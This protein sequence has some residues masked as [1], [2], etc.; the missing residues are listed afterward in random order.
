MSKRQLETEQHIWQLIIVVDLGYL[1][2]QKNPFKMG[3]DQELDI[4]PELEPDAASCFQTAISVLRWMIELGRIDIIMEVSLL[5]LHV[6]SP[7]RNA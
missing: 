4:S 2:K 5:S 3:Y 6:T 1:R 7:E